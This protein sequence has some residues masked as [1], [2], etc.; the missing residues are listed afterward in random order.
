MQSQT[1]NSFFSTTTKALRN[2]L[3]V[4]LSN[5]GR[6][7]IAIGTPI[8][9]LSIVLYFFITTLSGIC[10]SGNCWFGKGIMSY[11][12]G[13]EYRGDLFLRKAHGYGEFRSLKGERY[14]GE[15]TFGKKNGYG[16]YNY[17]NGDSYEGKFS[18]NVK[19]GFGVFTWKGGLRYLGNWEKGEP[20]GQGK[21]IL[22]NSNETLEG[23]YRNGIIHNGKGMYV[24][25]DGSKYIGE[26]KNGKREGGGILFDPDG[27]PVYSGPWVDDKQSPVGHSK[28]K[29]TS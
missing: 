15:W 18:S 11:S 23:E 22:E 9:F 12:D 6:R 19:E 4:L 2:L 28:G 20:S 26:W 3:K 24:Y 14:L 13:N 17:A 8:V 1:I 21:L 10:T 27:K 25:E 16:L 29:M 7:F 5:K